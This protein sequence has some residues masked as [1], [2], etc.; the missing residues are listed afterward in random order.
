M[1]SS[2]KQKTFVFLHALREVECVA[3]NIVPSME[4]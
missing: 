2:L 3:C 4:G 1:S